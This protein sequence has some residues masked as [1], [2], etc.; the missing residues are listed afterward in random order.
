MLRVIGNGTELIYHL[1]DHLTKFLSDQLFYKIKD[2]FTTYLVI[3]T[4]Y[5]DIRD[6]LSR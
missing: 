6:I 1:S 3:K 5:I 4:L 2:N